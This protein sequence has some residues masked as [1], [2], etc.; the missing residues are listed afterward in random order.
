MIISMYP[1]VGKTTLAKKRKDIVDFDSGVFNKEFRKFCPMWFELYCKIALDL[2][3]QGYIVLTC[4]DPQVIN[5]LNSNAIDFAVVFFKK[6]MKNYVVNNIKNRENTSLSTL[7]NVKR[8]FY[9]SSE[10]LK[11][12]CL[13]KS[14]FFYEITEENYILEEIIN[15][16]ILNKNN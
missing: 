1:G 12:I 8:N 5:Y 9:K 11:N 3:K 13:Q 2:E 6:N 16:I 15:E 7:N 4:T 10:R 14:I